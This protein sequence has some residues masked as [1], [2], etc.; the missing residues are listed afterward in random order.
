MGPD[1]WEVK[2]D[3]LQGF[4]EGLVIEFNKLKKEYEVLAKKIFCFSGELLESY[5]KS[6]V[7]I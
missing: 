6:R 2:N 1:E 4:W 5:E 3:D 7:E